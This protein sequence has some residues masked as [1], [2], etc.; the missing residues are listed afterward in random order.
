MGAEKGSGKGGPEKGVRKR[1]RKRGGVHL[2]GLGGGVVCRGRFF[3]DG[4]DQ[5][6]LCGF[7]RAF[8]GHEG[9]AQVV[10]EGWGRLLI[11][12]C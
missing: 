11:Y 5:Q 12:D 3:D 10:G 1:V 8:A 9:T 6:H 2:S 4:D 7:A